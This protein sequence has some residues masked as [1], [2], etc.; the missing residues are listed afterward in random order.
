MR[1]LVHAAVV[2]APLAV[3][4]TASTALAQDAQP[5]PADK[6]A[7][8]KPVPAPSPLPG[9]GPNGS[10]LATVWAYGYHHGKCWL[11]EMLLKTSGSGAHMIS[12]STIV[13]QREWPCDKVPAGIVPSAKTSSANATP[14][15]ATPPAGTTPGT[16]P[17][18]V[19]PPPGDPPPPPPG[20][21]NGVSKEFEGDD[22]IW[23]YPDGHRE[24]YR[25][26]KET[27]TPK[28][29]ARA[30]DQPNRRSETRTGNPKS[31]ARGDA[32]RKDSRATTVRQGAPRHADRMTTR[33]AH[34]AGTKWTAGSGR[35]MADART[36]SHAP[37]LGANAMRGGTMSR[38][39]YRAG[40]FSHFGGGRL[41]GIGFGRL[42]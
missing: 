33:A 18:T 13:S 5:K 41:A 11:Y 3:V 16:T 19:A 25:H 35:R 17:K 27:T 4:A 20:W 22:E 39:T 28:S 32:P 30:D 40:G 29:H 7:Q 37:R 31:E 38:A 10:G 36:A 26:P 15:T 1:S 12:I 9:Y 2:L 24:R 34:R 14:A 23:T 6:D 42:R 8:T 21:P